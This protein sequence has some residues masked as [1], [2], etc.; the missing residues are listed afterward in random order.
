[1]QHKC[2]RQR[3]NEER[4]WFYT[5]KAG[6]HTW[7]IGYCAGPPDP[8]GG[9]LIG[10]AFWEQWLKQC[11]PFKDKFHDDGHATAEEAAECYRQHLLDLRSRYDV[12]LGDYNPCLEC[13]ELTNKAAQVEGWHTFRLCALHLT[14]EVVAKHFEVLGESW[15]W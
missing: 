13:G 8:D 15:E 6:G 3:D 9:Q 2:A 5:T 11:E 7:A 12:T 4:R 1:M 14:P 10:L